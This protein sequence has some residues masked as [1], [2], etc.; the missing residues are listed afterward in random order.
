MAGEVKACAARLSQESGLN[1]KIDLVSSYSAIGFYRD[2]A[3]VVA[4][5]AARLA[6]S[7]M[8]GVSGAATTRCTWPGWHPAA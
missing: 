8:P 5:A 1:I 4:R 2:C 3:D 6:Y 7:N